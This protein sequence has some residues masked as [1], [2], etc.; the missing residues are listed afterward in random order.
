MFGEFN[1]F[2]KVCE[3][4]NRSWGQRVWKKEQ[5]RRRERRTACGFAEKNSVKVNEIIQLVKVCDKDS[6]KIL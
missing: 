5:R 1:L 6:C 3:W 2:L 4:S